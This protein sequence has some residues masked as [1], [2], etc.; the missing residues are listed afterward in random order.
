MAEWLAH[1][2]CTILKGSGGVLVMWL[3]V[4]LMQKKKDAASSG[5]LIAVAVCRYHHLI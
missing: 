1:L 3:M 2:Y 5:M 4:M